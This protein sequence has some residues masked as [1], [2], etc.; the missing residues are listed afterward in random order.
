MK[1]RADPLTLIAI[2]V[3]LAVMLQP[4]WPGGFRVGFFLT[5]VATVAQ[6]VAS[7]LGGE[8]SR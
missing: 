4:F 2:A 6:V 5:L 7:H 8:E 1:R 3:G